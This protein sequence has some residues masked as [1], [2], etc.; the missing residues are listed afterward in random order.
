M[1]PKCFSTKKTYCKS[2]VSNSSQLLQALDCCSVFDHNEFEVDKSEAKLAPFPLITYLLP[3]PQ[4]MERFWDN[5]FRA[6]IFGCLEGKKQQ[7]VDICVEYT[8]MKTIGFNTETVIKNQ[9]N[10][11]LLHCGT[12]DRCWLLVAI[13]LF[14]SMENFLLKLKICTLL[15]ITFCKNKQ[16]GKKGRTVARSGIMLKNKNISAFKRIW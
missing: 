11:W 5:F 3:L 7:L 9:Y 6:Q 10:S 14:F 2:F 15:K 8:Y 1:L 16:L 13:R 12:R 4:V